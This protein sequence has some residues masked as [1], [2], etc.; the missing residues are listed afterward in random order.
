M[1]TFPEAEKRLFKNIYICRKCESKTR[2]PIR[3]VLTGNAVCR[4]CGSK[5]MRT[6][7]K[8]SKN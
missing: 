8:K 5:Q 4:K 1:A 7:R 2:I 6:V 3:K